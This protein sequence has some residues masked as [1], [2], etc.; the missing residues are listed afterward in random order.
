MSNEDN[1]ILKN[2]HGGKSLKVLFMIY[3]DFECLLEKMHSCQ[4]NLGKSYTGKIAKHTLSGYS[5]FTNCLFDATKNK[6]DCYRGKGCMETF[7]KD[8][9]QHAI[10]II[11]CEKKE[12]I[13]LTD[14][15]NKSYEKQK[16]C[17]I[18]KKEFSTDENDKNAFK[19]YHKV[20]DHC[21]YTGKFRG[22]A[23][24]ICNLR[25]KT[26]KEIPAVFHNGSAFDYHFK[27]KQLAKDLKVNL[28]ALEKIQKNI[29]LFSTN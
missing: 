14:K 11:D 5:L 7:Y 1:K 24:N 4:N 21:H 10:K 13:P 29:L 22:A 23:H 2:N 26:P 12:M 25:Y 3:A 20:R 17:Y 16:V 18:C 27:I 6:L 9:R 19:L 15:E 8:L 28:N